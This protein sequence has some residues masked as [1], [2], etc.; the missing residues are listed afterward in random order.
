MAKGLTNRNRI[1]TLTKTSETTKGETT[2]KQ[3]TANVA[4]SAQTAAKAAKNGA[5]AKP[6][7]T[8][9]AKA[10]EAT[11][12]T[13][14][15]EEKRRGAVPTMPAAILYRLNGR[16]FAAVHSP[17]DG[18]S[19]IQSGKGEGSAKGALEDTGFRLSSLTLD[20]AEWLAAKLPAGAELI[21]YAAI[22]GFPLPEQD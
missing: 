17:V 7:E 22:K 1:T 16:V 8:D 12:P 20:G 3:D 11:K 19:Y 15:T 2:M 21:G 10:A 14:A 9:A 5:E 13:E 6:A 4:Q 18:K